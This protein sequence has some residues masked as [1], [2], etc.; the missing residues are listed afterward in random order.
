MLASF[1]T[2]LAHQDAQGSASQNHTRFPL[3]LAFY[4]SSKGDTLLYHNRLRIST[5]K[6]NIPAVRGIF[7]TARTYHYMK[8]YSR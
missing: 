6:K 3:F 5:P 2:L 1:C 4:H 7:P 8:P